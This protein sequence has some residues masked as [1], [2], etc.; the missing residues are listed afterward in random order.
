MSHPTDL[1][2]HIGKY[3]VQAELG[4][5]ATGVV[6]L[7]VDGFKGRQVAIKEVHAHLLRKPDDAERYRKLLRNEVMLTARLRHPNIVRLLDADEQAT[8]PYLVLE[9]VDGQPL[10]AFT[11]PDTLLPVAQ[12]LDIAYKCCNA[13]EHAQREGLVHRDIKPAN[14]LLSQEG[15]VKLTD[16]GA[17]LAVRSDAT[18]L[19][20]LVGSPSYMSPEQVQEQ[21][22]THHSDMFSLAVVVYELLTGRRPF[23]AETDFATLYRITHEAPTAPRLLR[24]DLPEHLDAVL[25]R[26]LAKQ[27]QDR[28]AT[29]ADFANALLAV[30]HALPAQRSQDSEAQRFALLRALPFFADFHDVALWELMRLGRWRWA[31]K[32][33]VILFEGQPGDSF[34]VLVEGRVSITREGWQLSTLGPGVTL[35]EMTYLQPEHKIRSATA[36]AETDVLVLKV[37]NP[38]LMEASADLQSRFDKAFI[39]VLVSRLVATSK[40]LGAWELSAPQD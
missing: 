14:V 26:A 37:R 18:Q 6:Y 7:A 40:Q 28:F 11:T 19:A 27:P 34:Y 1:P 9:Y 12:V 4:R 17:A 32:G 5:G 2:F 35:G 29:W 33:K 39:K 10:S 25:L 15:E 36:V 16:F 23:D 3:Q 31:P 20:G 8:Q 38:S 30:Q 24:T 13:L 21:D 22:L